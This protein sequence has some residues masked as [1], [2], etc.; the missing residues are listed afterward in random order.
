MSPT[1]PGAMALLEK[2][3]A[4][5]RGMDEARR[6]NSLTKSKMDSVRQQIE[7]LRVERQ[8]MEAQTQ[9]AREDTVDLH[10]DVQEAL[11]KLRELEDNHAQALLE[12]M[13]AQRQ[14][15]FTRQYVEADASFRIGSRRRHGNLQGIFGASWRML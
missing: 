8:D 6:E 15:D 1:A 10:K 5:N 3:S 14:L 2:Y 11:A 7:R 9:D 12:K 13:G 4:L